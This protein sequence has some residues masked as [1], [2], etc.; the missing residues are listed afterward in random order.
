VVVNKP[1]PELVGTSWLNVTQPVT[2][3]SR[4]GKVTVVEFWTADC[5]NCKR[6]FPTYASWSR[7][8]QRD[9][10]QVLSIHTPETKW[11]AASS[12]VR[13]RTKEY[14][15]TY[16]VLIDSSYSNWNLWHQDS[17]PTVYLIDKKGI[18]RYQ[19]VGELDADGAGGTRQM[20][21]LINRL[22]H[23]AG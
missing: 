5:I 22:V 3:A 20:T 17:W 4:R 15:I 2:L 11:E 14:K 10:V 8:F 18:I 12:F 19:W 1:A 9:G 7:D 6:N 16:P 21:Q 23:S 13:R